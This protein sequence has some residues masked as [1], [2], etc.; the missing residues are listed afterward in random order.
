MNLSGASDV[1]FTTDGNLLK[2]E[3]PMKGR[4]IIIKGAS[5]DLKIQIHGKREP[6]AF[7]TPPPPSSGLSLR[8]RQLS[9]KKA[10]VLATVQVCCFFILFFLW[11]NND[12]LK[13]KKK[14]LK[15]KTG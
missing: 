5:S 10:R 12:I 15:K 11:R 7:K 8:R 14:K 1:E 2:L 6:M 13:I 9:R 3:S 4:L